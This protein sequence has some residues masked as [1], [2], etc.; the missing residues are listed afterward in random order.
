MKVLLI[1]DDKDL[2]EILSQFLEREQHHVVEVA[3]D[4]K[5]A[6]Q[7]LN[8]Y[9][10]DC[11]LLDVLLPDGSGLDVLRQLKTMG[12]R[13]NV[14]IISA[15]D[16]VDDKVLGLELGADD[17]LAKPFHL[18]ELN[19]RLHSVIRRHHFGGENK[20]VLGNVELF[21]AERK[22]MVAGRELELLRKEYDILAYFMSRPGRL[23]DKSA[24]S[25]AV[26]GDYIDQVDN[27][28]FLYAQM[29]NLR[30]HLKS[31][32]ATIEIKAVYGVGYKLVT[33]EAG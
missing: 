12:K 16:S 8:D 22:V 20:V 3:H 10:Y 23:V 9:D 17:Y 11:V 14:I 24:L 5:T 30:K 31:V 33:D 32:Q 26:W 27:F 7:K 21:P 1:E 2:R 28:D 19:A 25:E 15:K 29:R 13:E 6:V 18:S 4:F